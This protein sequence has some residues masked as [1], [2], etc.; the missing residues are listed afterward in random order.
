IPY[1][2]SFKISEEAQLSTL[3]NED[4]TPV[5]LFEQELI[6]LRATMDVGFMIVK[7]EAFGKISPKA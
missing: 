3:T 5:N 4:G 7:D 1:N 2:I 6:A